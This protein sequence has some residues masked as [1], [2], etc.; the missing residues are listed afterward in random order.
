[1]KNKLLSI[2]AEEAHIVFGDYMTKGLHGIW[3]LCRGKKYILYPRQLIKMLLH[4][5]GELTASCRDG[6]TWNGN[7]VYYQ[8][9]VDHYRWIVTD[10]ADK[11]AAYLL[12]PK[13]RIH[14]EIKKS[15]H[16]PL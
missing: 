11:R 6:E 9:N 7:I 15:F 10:Y 1:M 13:D 8:D 16:A 4:K 14:E 5:S 12:F 2:Q 3:L